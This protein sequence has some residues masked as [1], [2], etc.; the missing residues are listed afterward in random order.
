[1]FLQKYN[2]PKLIQ[3]KKNLNSAIIVKEIVKETDIL[4]KICPYLKQMRLNFQKTD[5]LKLAKFFQT[6]DRKRLLPNL[7]NKGGVGG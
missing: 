3:A 7:F 1:M 2:L 4:V 5:H 6:T